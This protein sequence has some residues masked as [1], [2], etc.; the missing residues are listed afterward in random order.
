MAFCF[1]VYFAEEF[2]KD[3]RTLE[4]KRLF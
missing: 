2:E 1:L 3:Q 4:K